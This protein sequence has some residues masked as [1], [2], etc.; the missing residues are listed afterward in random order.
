[1]AGLR[2]GPGDRLSTSARTG[3]LRRRWTAV[4]GAGGAGSGFS[5][6]L[7][8]DAGAAGGVQPTLAPGRVKPRR[9]GV[10]PRP[11]P[12]T[13]ARPVLP[14]P[15]IETRKTAVPCSTRPPLAPRPPRGRTSGGGGQPPAACSAL[16][17]RHAAGA[18]FWL[19]R[20]A[21][22]VGR[23]P[24]GGATIVD[25]RLPPGWDAILSER[26]WQTPLFRD[27]REVHLTDDEA[28]AHGMFPRTADRIGYPQ[29]GARRPVPKPDPRR[30]RR[31]RWSGRTVFAL[32]ARLPV[33]TRLALRTRFTRGARRANGTGRARGAR[34]RR[35]S[36]GGSLRAG[37]AGGTGQAR[38]TR[39]A[40][41][42]RN[43]WPTGWP[44]IAHGSGAP[45]WPH[46]T[47]RSRITRRTRWPGRPR[48]PGAA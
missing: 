47:R 19:I 45:A 24:R 25:G 8:R 9:S 18:I 38:R 26:R 10:P 28:A 31:S 34:D 5:G 2:A 23:D 44:A 41:G 21:E 4:A 12:C 16:G 3:G 30:G 13:A 15:R 27:R 46:R 6:G 37:W 42:A 35:G 48:R 22:H 17:H 43:T 11:P 36:P 7:L 32:S 39:L 20:D 33:R 14:V 1:M 29:S 40:L